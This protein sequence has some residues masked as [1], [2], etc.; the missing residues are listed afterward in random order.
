MGD[1]GAVV[2]AALVAASGGLV[3]PSL[4]ARLPEPAPAGPDPDELSAGAP[5]GDGSVDAR[6][7]AAPTKPAYADL[8]AT[9]GLGLACALVAAVVAGTLGWRLGWSPALPVWI[10]LSVVGVLLA[11]VDSRTRLLPTVVIAPSYLV[12]VALVLVT[13]VVTGDWQSALRAGLG[14]L[15][16]GGLFFLLWFIHP[17]GMGYGDVR[18]AGLLGL[19]LGWL[20]WAELVVGIYA[21]FCLGAVVGGVLALAKVVDRRRYPFGPFL[22]LGAVVGVL[23]GPAL[24]GWYTGR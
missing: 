15:G 7:A 24:G 14:W 13:S 1:T 16:A 9:P 23:W 12:V 22:L 20:G 4:V 8:A 21:S 3:V 2:L 19:A 5:G 11:F 6:P 18:L 17:K 10:Y